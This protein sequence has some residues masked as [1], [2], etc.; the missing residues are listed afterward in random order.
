MVRNVRGVAT[1][2]YALIPGA[3][4]VVVF[5]SY[6]VVVRS[7]GS[8][9]SGVDSALTPRPTGRRCHS[10]RAAVKDQRGRVGDRSRR[11][12]PRFGVGPRQDVAVAE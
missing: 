10:R 7:V 3:F 2:E 6:L 9:A 4:A 8:L 1:V 11:T 5:A 12:E